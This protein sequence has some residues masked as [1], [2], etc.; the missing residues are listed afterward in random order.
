MKNSIAFAS[1]I[2]LVAISLAAGQATTAAQ[3]PP[4]AAPA[5]PAGQP[6]A[7]PAPPRTP[8]TIAPID[9]TGYWVPVITED[10]RWRMLT[11]PKGDYA[12]VP[13]NDEGRRVADA[14][15][16]S[17]DEA[18]GLSCKPYGIGNI[19]RMPGRMHVTWQDEETL[20]IDPFHW[21][22]QTFGH[23]RVTAQTGWVFRPDGSSGMRSRCKRPI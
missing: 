7:P 10:W 18:G 13:I 19:M 22:N 8:R 21:Y 2:A 12:S 4:A 14:W 23:S 11:P 1:A 3:Q 15:N 6:P 20:R 17:K 9:I 16:L 5:A